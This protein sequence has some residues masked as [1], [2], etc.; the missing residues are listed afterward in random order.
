M[1]KPKKAR[2]ARISFQ[3]PHE[4]RD[5][6]ERAAAADRRTLSSWIVCALADAV[7]PREAK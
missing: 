5:A 2:R 7:S 6:L 3:V 4:L 1:T